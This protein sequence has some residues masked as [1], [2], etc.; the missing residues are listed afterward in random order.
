[1]ASYK[2]LFKQTFIYGLATVLPRALSII[3]VPLYVSNLDKGDYG[4]YASLFAFIIFGNVLL[5]YGMETAYFRFLH[6]KDEDPKRV[7]STSLTSLAITS[8]LF[9]LITLPNVDFIARVL[10]FH[11]EYIQYTIWILAL[12]ALVV[13]PFSWFRAR[14]KPMRY[15][16]LRIVNVSINLGLNLFFFLL[17][18]KL[19]SQNIGGFWGSLYQPNNM[20]SYVFISNLVASALTLGFVLPLYFRI[21]FSWNPALWRRMLRYAMPILLAGIAFSINEA[22]DK[23]LLKYLLPANIADSEVGVYAACYK[24]GVFMT[25]FATA[26]RLG[27]EPFFFKQAEEKNAPIVYATITK[28]FTLLGSIIFLAVMVYIDIFKALLITDASYWVA[29]DIVPIILLANLFLGMYHNLSVWYKITDRTKVGA[30]ISI[31]G[32]LSTIVGNFL[33]IPYLSYYGSALATLFAYGLMMLLSYLFGQKY[34]PIPYPVKQILVYLVIS[35]A[36]SFLAFYIFEGS[37]VLGTLLLLL[38]TGIL[39]FME[40]E[41]LQQLIKR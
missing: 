33:L 37:L 24:L 14:E 9:L 30:Y 27:V 36:F 32:A 12:D 10:D 31:V 29:M 16:A 1:M 5:S 25:L 23:I 4:I 28:Y 34:Y 8:L 20:I 18:P 7:E 40:K 6:R 38:Y 15:A 11:A 35:T 21:G 13:I 39:I 2:N 22:L 41:P 26:F 3:L 17:L 19:A